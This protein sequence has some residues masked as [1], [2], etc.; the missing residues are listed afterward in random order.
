M[1]QFA[2]A[3]QSCGYADYLAQYMTFPPSGVQPQLDG[4]YNTSSDNC[5]VWTTAYYA[6]YQPNPCFNVYEV[7]RIWAGRSEANLHNV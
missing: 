3:H 2:N 1:A 5:D 4:M 6:A 7:C